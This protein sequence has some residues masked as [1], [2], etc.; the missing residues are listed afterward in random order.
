M[1]NF[2]SFRRSN[3]EFIAILSP[4]SASHRFCFPAHASVCVCCS[5]LRSAS[6]SGLAVCLFLRAAPCATKAKGKRHTQRTRHGQGKKQNKAKGGRNKKRHTGRG[7]G[8]REETRQPAERKGKQQAR[9]CT[10][11]LPLLS[12]HRPALTVRLCSV[13]SP[14]LPASP[15]VR[16]VRLLLRVGAL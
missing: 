12:T 8:R 2:F 16:S 4:R 10:R 3:L 6:C 1:R 7:R 14:L 5:S 13:L 9:N 15:L 11:R